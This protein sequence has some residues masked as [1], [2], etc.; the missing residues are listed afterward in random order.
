MLQPPLMTVEAQAALLLLLPTFLWVLLFVRKKCSVIEYTGSLLGFIFQFQASLILNI[1]LLNLGLI[2]FSPTSSPLFYGVPID[3]LIGQSMLT[4][5]IFL[6]LSKWPIRFSLLVTLMLNGCLYAFSSL[7]VLHS[8]LGLLSLIS[9]VP[10]LVLADCTAKDSNIYLRSILQGLSWACLLIWLFPSLIFQNTDH[11][12][13]VFLNRSVLLN[14]IYLLPLTVPAFLLINALWQFA[15]EGQGTAFPYDPPKILVTGG[16]YGYLS[17]PMQL[18][19]CLLVAW[20]GVVFQSLLLSLSAVV[21]VLLFIVFK[22]ICNG[23]CG[24]AE[25]D[26]NWAIYHNAVPK[27]LPRLTAWHKKV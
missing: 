15:H 6:L 4:P 17:N 8:Y 9:T 16:I 11:S 7:V 22:D 18:G 1:V 5:V 26:P 25:T 12:W 20:E 21:A 3:F 10:S 13:S 14:I 27:W 19:I 24:I 2:T 23:S